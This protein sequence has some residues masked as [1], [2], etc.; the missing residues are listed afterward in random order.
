VSVVRRERR[1]PRQEAFPESAVMPGVRP[2]QALAGVNPAQLV[3]LGFF[4][5]FLSLLSCLEIFALRDLI[6]FFRA[7]SLFDFFDYL[8][9]SLSID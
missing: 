2:G 1:S 3:F 6:S 4:F 8:A 7:F 9:I 5:S